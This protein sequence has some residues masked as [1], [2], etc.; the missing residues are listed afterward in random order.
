ML[1]AALLTTTLTYRV[2]EGLLTP[3]AV[4][5]EDDLLAA[6]APEVAEGRGCAPVIPSRSRRTVGWDEHAPSAASAVL[7]GPNSLPMVL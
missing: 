1:L 5:E 4:I 7:R 2:T 3:V 6:G